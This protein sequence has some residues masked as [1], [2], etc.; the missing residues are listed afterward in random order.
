MKKT[1]CICKFNVH[2][3]AYSHQDGC[4]QWCYVQVVHLQCNNYHYC[5]CDWICLQM[6]MNL[7]ISICSQ[8]PKLID[9][10]L[11]TLTLGQDQERENVGF[12]LSFESVV[13]TRQQRRGL[14]YSK[15]AQERF[16]R[17]RERENISLHI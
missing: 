11:F 15:T 14:Y 7:H 4:V 1:P 13:S 3:V 2:R 16:P 8:S 6:V 9:S 17:P 12:S 5:D 10:D